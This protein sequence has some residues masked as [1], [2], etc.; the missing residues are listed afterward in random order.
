MNDVSTPSTMPGAQRP[1]PASWG[2]FGGPTLRRLAGAVL[3][4]TGLA[5]CGGVATG[6]GKNSAST[7]AAAAPS[8][9]DAAIALAQQ[10]L[11]ALPGDRS[12][13]DDL[14]GAYLQKVREVGDPSYYPKADSLLQ[15][16][17]GAAPSDERALLLMGTLDLARHQFGDA[18]QWGRRAGALDPAGS[19]PYG[20]IADALVEL[21]RYDEALTAVQRMVDLRPDLGSYARV[22]YLRELHGDLDGAAAAMRMAVEAGAT[23][24]ENLAYVEVLL[25]NLL[26]NRGDLAGADGQYAQALHDDPGYVHALAASARVRAARGD[27]AGA[28][29]LYQRVVDVY[30]MPQYVV[31]LGDVATARGDAGEASRDYALA[32]AEQQLLRAGGVDVDQELALFDADH[33]RDLPGALVAAR[34]AVQDRPSVQS[35]DVLS[36]TLYQSGDA[37][38]AYAASQQARRLG[39]RDSLF[40]FHAGMVEKALGMNAPARGDLRAALDLNPH[41]SVLQPP[42]A[43]AALAELGG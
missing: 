3:V 9:T 38:G 24:P 12:A 31:A 27:L 21:G 43:T 41:F 40:L 33:R 23:V 6:S 39:T 20:V 15:S 17:L 11:R 4:A 30:P 25:G 18:L 26:F 7:P 14:A 36:W 10:R 29:A 1:I 22:S 13:Q 19:G 34:R 16:A 32:D 37:Q 8:H 35:F 2:P 5:A 28:A 42:V